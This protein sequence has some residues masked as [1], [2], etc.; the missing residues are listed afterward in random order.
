[1]SVETPVGEKKS[2]KR[3]FVPSLALA[4]FATGTAGAVLTLF[5]PEIANTF[6]GSTSRAAIGVAGQTSTVNNTAEVV[7]AFLMSILAIRF[8]HKWLLLAG[9]VLVA[10]S[11]LGSFL[12]PDFFTFQIFFA[13]EG[14]GSVM[15][16][17]LAFTLIGDTLPFNKKPRA[18]S[19]MSASLILS[20]L[21]GM[22][23][24]Y[25]LGNVAGWRSGFLLLGLP[26]SIAG[27][28]LVSF[29][30]QS[31]SHA[32]Q[33]RIDKGAY[34]RAFK[35]VLLNK[36]AFSCLIGRMVGSASVVG[37]FVLTFYRQQLSLS[38]GW[39]LGIALINGGLFVIGSLVGGLL[40][41]RFG[42]KS[43]TVICGLISGVLTV[44]FFSMPNLWLTLAFNFASVIIG[45]CVIPAIICLTVD[46]APKSRGTMLSIHRIVGNAG[47]AIGAA[48]GGA[49]IAL[50]SFQ[51]FGIGCGAFTIASALI[52]LFLVKQ[53]TET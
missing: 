9:A 3:L 31:K 42:S 12:A 27:L 53:P 18:I 43:V 6:L 34:V 30:V 38:Q 22:I 45:A 47:E 41:N 29:G 24:L 14:A 37:L 11:S 10:F 50:F 20:G 44:A 40:I 21:I 23:V 35:Q 32:Q 28:I 25:F 2:P 49:L 48:V 1:M 16:S 7:L 5:L 8:R 51:V 19:Y 13:M 39:A 52:F 4:V 33:T 46:Q 36:S 17:I 26:L 15:V